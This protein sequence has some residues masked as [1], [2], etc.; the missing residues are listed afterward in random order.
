MSS[1]RRPPAIGYGPNADG[2]ADPARPSIAER[3]R[4]APERIAAE[5]ADRATPSPFIRRLRA[6]ARAALKPGKRGRK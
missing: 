3:V 6:A 5:R 2:L 4:L 1:K